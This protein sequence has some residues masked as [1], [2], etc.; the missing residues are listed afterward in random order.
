MKAIRV[1]KQAAGQVVVH[2]SQKG[3]ERHR[4]PS[5]GWTEAE[6]LNPGERERL[7]MHH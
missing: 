1:L 7:N 5:T 6:H 4:V 2:K 3:G